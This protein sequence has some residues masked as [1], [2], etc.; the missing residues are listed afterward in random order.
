[1]PLRGPSG[2]PL[3]VRSSE[4]LGI[5]ARADYLETSRRISFGSKRPYICSTVME[6]A[7]TCAWRVLHSDAAIE[8]ATLF[9]V[10]SMS[11]NQS[12]FIRRFAFLFSS[13]PAAAQATIRNAFFLFSVAKTG[14]SAMR[15]AECT[16]GFPPA[17]GRQVVLK[18]DASVSMF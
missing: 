12:S 11:L 7:C 5:T 2:L 13:L 8:K 14:A 10:V 16:P 17:D 1:M 9:L 3:G 15:S 6:P 18:V 4:G